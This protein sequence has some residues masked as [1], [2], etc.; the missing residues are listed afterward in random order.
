MEVICPTKSN[1]KKS[2]Q[3]EIQIWT[4]FFIV[5]KIFLGSITQSKWGFSTSVSLLMWR[6]TIPRRES[7]YK[8]L[9]WSLFT[10]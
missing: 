8:I 6:K 10:V 7:A 3:S 1:K 4:E 5:L 2:K 9:Y